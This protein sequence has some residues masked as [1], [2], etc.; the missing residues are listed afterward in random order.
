MKHL[1]TFLL[2]AVCLVGHAVSGPVTMEGAAQSQQ[3]NLERAQILDK[4]APGPPPFTNPNGL[5]PYNFEPR[6][7][8]PLITPFV[9]FHPTT[10]NLIDADA[11]QSAQG[12]CMLEMLTTDPYA[13]R[14]LHLLIPIIFHLCATQL[15]SNSLR[16]SATSRPPNGGR[17][18]VQGQND[19]VEGV[20]LLK[21]LPHIADTDSGLRIRSSLTF[22]EYRRE[23]SS[24]SA[25]AIIA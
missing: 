17:L 10:H 11:D 16:S 24:S 2:V 23:S 18:S 12:A 25:R 3:H 9:L 13:L 6:P 8:T 22:A 4:R 20:S 5:P 1:R 15:D 14:T 19:T 21:S 7:N